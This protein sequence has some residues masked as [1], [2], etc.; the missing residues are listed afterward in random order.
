MT[1]IRSRLGMLAAALGLLVAVSAMAAEPKV[2]TDDAFL[3]GRLTVDPR[4]HLPQG[5]IAARIPVNL[6]LTNTGAEPLKLV[7]PSLCLV[8]NY[9]I[10]RPNME[11]VAAK[12]DTDCSGGETSTVIGAGETIYATNTLAV[13]R[14]MLRDGQ[15]YFV[16]Y[17]FW[18]VRMR[19][20]FSIHPE[21]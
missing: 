3:Q 9:R 11:V 14:Q 8:H 17:E 1:R 10:V 21:E 6:A 5:G 16:I 13:S 18:G 2:A 20:P 12:G 7:A 19:A 15:R 4:V